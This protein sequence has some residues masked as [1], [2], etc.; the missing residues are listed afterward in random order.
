MHKHSY[1]ISYI[2]VW[3]IDIKECNLEG[4][5][6]VSLPFDSDGWK[7]LGWFASEEVLD[8]TEPTWLGDDVQEN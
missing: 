1:T 5:G 3:A 2:Q 4:G 8:R 7:C 6:D